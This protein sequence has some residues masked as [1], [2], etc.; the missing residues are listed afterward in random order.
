MPVFQYVDGIEVGNGGTVR[1]ENAFAYHVARL[2]GKPM[3]GGS[4]AHSVNGFA[5]YTTGFD[6]VL[7][8]ESDLLA[9]LRANAS[10]CVEDLHLGDAR[11]FVPAEEEALPRA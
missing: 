5:S 2:L 8:S 7:T 4:D 3:V 11:E 1:A 9:A 6:E 10:T